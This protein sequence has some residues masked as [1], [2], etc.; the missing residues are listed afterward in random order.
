MFMAGFGDW[1]DWTRSLKVLPQRMVR[2][3]GMGRGYQNGS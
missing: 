1:G 3:G 2:W